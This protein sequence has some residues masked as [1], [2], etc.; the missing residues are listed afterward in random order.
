MIVDRRCRLNVYVAARHFDPSESI[1]NYVESH[2]V[3]PIRAHTGLDISR[4]EVQLF[5]DGDPERRFGCHVLVSVKGDHD[6][7]VREQDQTLYAAVDVAKD[8]VLRRLTELRH[9]LT[10]ARRHPQK[11]HLSRLQ[12]ALGWIGRNAHA[13]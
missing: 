11:H 8:R 6:I 1:R 13:D 5:T 7:N 12:R 9:R 10:S 2:L 4:V 3:E